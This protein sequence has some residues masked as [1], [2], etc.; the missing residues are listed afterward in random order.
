MASI[1]ILG[2]ACDLIDTHQQ[3]KP[4]PLSPTKNP[5]KTGKNKKAQAHQDISKQASSTDLQSRAET[6]DNDDR[7]SKVA[8]DL[9]RSSNLFAESLRISL[10]NHSAFFEGTPISL[11][12][13]PPYGFVEKLDSISKS[14]SV[15]L[16]E[17]EDLNVESRS[18]PS[19]S[20]DENVS[21]HSSN[22]RWSNSRS[23]KF[24][25]ARGEFN[26]SVYSDS[27][28]RPLS[29]TPPSTSLSTSASVEED[30][31]VIVLHTQ[32][33]QNYPQQQQ[34]QNVQRDHWNDLKQATSHDHHLGVEDLM[35]GNQINQIQ[36]I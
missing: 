25:V 9:E 3:T 13:N 4:S 20:D 17:E 19:L 30:D 31:D 24:L 34:P 7:A 23:S 28:R 5:D 2:K 26:K 6:A 29:C 15:I 36:G 10:N 21:T 14:S 11:S 22:H 35:P 33:Q 12:S 8:A 16:E 1:V 27:R 32:Q 18:V